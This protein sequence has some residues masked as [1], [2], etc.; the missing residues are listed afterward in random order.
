MRL[1]SVLQSLKSVI[2]FSAKTQKSYLDQVIDA[3]H[4]RQHTSLKFSR[5]V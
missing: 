3:R 1:E 5:Q 4:I 2:Y